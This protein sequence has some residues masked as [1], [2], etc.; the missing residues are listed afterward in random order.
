[1]YTLYKHFSHAVLSA[2]LN[3]KDFEDWHISQDS[4]VGNDKTQINQT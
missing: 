3:C 1:M 4:Y 2:L